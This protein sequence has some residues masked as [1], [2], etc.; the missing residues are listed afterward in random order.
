MTT[1]GVGFVVGKFCPLTKGHELLINYAATQCERL[2]VLSYASLV[3][4]GCHADE[5]KYWLETAFGH[6]DNVET[7]VLEPTFIPLDHDDADFHRRFCLDF[8]IDRCDA[9]VNAIFT[10]EEYGDGFAAFARDYYKDRF[11]VS[12]LVE[13]ICVDIK[14]AAIPISGTEA[15]RGIPGQIPHVRPFVQASLVPRIAILGGESSGKTMLSKALADVLGTVWVPEYGRTL[16]EE[17]GGTDQ[18]CYNDMLKIAETQVDEER[19]LGRHAHGYLVCDTTPLTT[20]WYS[21][22]LFNSHVSPRLREL[23]ER[24]YKHH[25]LCANDFPFVQD[26]TRES[27]EFRDRGFLW[28]GTMLKHRGIPFHVISG[29]VEQRVKQIVDYLA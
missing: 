8:C 5:R 1:Y 16:T 23:S 19:K 26:G 4:P 24:P 22:E 6:M 10:S 29:T 2:I 14:R 17:I 7:Y 11:S 25:F 27:P 18:L 21:K 28:H 20:M 9:V 3:H 13:H 15:R 12:H